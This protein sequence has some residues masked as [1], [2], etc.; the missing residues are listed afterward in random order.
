MYRWSK[1]SR[2]I[3]TTTDHILQLW[4]DELIT[5]SKIDLAIHYTGGKRTAELQNQ[6]FKK[7]VSKADGYENESYHQT[8]KAIDICAYVN[9]HISWNFE[10]LCYIGGLGL[11]VFEDLK[12]QGVLPDGIYL[13]W[14]GLWS[15]KDD[16]MGWDKGHFEL[17]D[18]PQ[19]PKA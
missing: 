19:I 18:K 6:L 9:G 12:D 4:A 15:F 1:K 13:H 7:G 17:R 16:D 5:R 10:R 3:I 11:E 2:D 14:G 8:G